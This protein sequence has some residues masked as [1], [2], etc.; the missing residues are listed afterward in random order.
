M[1]PAAAAALVILLSACGGTEAE[2]PAPVTTG[3]VTTSPVTTSAVGSD[4]DALAGSEWVAAAIDDGSPVVIPASD[5]AA[6]TLIFDAVAASIRGSTGC[7]IFEGTVIVGAGNLAVGPLAVTERACVDQ[8]LMARESVYLR[9]LSSAVVFTLAD[10]VLTLSGEHGSASF[11]RPEEVVDVSLDDTVWTLTT[12]ISGDAATS[13]LATTTPTMTIDTTSSSIRGTTGCNDFFGTALVNAPSIA[14]SELSWTEVACEEGVMR[15]EAA[16]LAV[17]HSADRLEIE[18][19]RL[20]LSGPG[21]L[22]LVYR[23]G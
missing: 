9:I 17:L 23:A 5:A 2:D 14:I 22:A 1:L 12:L 6:P 7:N 11:V 15:Q 3:P 20:T 19:D 18:G 8:A 10:D 21:G 16:I 4:A 13:V